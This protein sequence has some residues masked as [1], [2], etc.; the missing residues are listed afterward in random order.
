MM[1]LERSVAFEKKETWFDSKVSLGLGPVRLRKSCF[2]ISVVLCVGVLSL[3]MYFVHQKKNLLE[4]QTVSDMDLDISVDRKDSLQMNITNWDKM[5]IRVQQNRNKPTLLNITVDSNSSDKS[6]SELY[7]EL[8]RMKEN[9]SYSLNETQDV[10]EANEKMEN[11]SSPS[12]KGKQGATFKKELKLSKPSCSALFAG[13]EFE[14]ARSIAFSNKNPYSPKTDYTLATRSCKDFVRNRGYIINS[15]PEETG[16]PIAFSIVMYKDVEQVERLLRAIYRPSNIYCIHMDGKT[17][18]QVQLQM[19]SIVT[20]FPNVFFS[21]TQIN[22]KWGG[23]SVLEAELVCMKDLLKYPGWTYFI[24]LTGQEFPLKTNLEIVR[25]LKIMNGANSVDANNQRRW[26][27]R[28]WAKAFPPPHGIHPYKGNVHVVVSRGFVDYA[29]NDPVAQNF[30]DWLKRTKVPDETFFGTLNNNPKLRV[31]GSSLDRISTDYD[32][33]PYI[34][35]FKNWGPQWGEKSFDWPCK[36][37][38]VRSICI[39]GVGDLPLLSSRRELFANKFHI[40]YQPQTYDCMDEWIRNRTLQ[41]YN[42]TFTMNYD[43]Y[44]NMPHSKYIYRNATVN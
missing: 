9:I 16:F 27:Q 5:E 2:L 44:E 37:K 38:R 43:F 23:F 32:L 28:R 24:N 3:E 25:V 12:I 17:A 15:N 6:V 22:V 26:M 11:I 1:R 39:F 13:N 36:G 42:G 21:S 4:R 29:I 41:E 8:Q 30:T 33:K 7:S 40:D 14:K 34:A 20:C 10:K 18:V 35:R 31:P 19:K